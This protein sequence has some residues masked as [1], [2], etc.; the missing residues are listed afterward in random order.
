MRFS[1]Y[2]FTHMSDY[3]QGDED[4]SNAFHRGVDATTRDAENEQIQAAL[5][6]S[7][8]EETIRQSRLEEDARGGRQ[9]EKGDGP[10]PAEDDSDQGGDDYKPAAPSRRGGDKEALQPRTRYNR[11]CKSQSNSKHDGTVA[12]GDVDWEDAANKAEEEALA[13]ED[14]PMQVR[15]AHTDA[16]TKNTPMD[17]ARYEALPDTNK[18]GATVCPGQRCTANNAKGKQCG[19]RT[20]N[21]Q[22][23][24]THTQLIH[25]VRIKPSTIKNAGKGLFA[26]KDT[27]T[28]TNIAAY[29]GDLTTGSKDDYGGSKYV[30]ELSRGY[31]IDARRTNTAPGRMINDPRGTGQRPNCEFRADQRAKTITLWTTRPVAKGEE[32]T[33]SYGKEFWKRCTARKTGVKEHSGHGAQAQEPDWESDF[34]EEANLTDP[35]GAAAPADDG[36]PAEGGLETKIHPDTVRLGIPAT[37]KQARNRSDTPHWAAS[38]MKE[39]RSHLKKKTYSIVNRS[40]MPPG[41]IVLGT[42][43]VYAL[44][45]HSDGTPKMYK[46][47]FTIRGDEQR[48]GID[49]KDTRAGVLKLGSLRTLCALAAKHDLEFEASDVETAFLHGELSEPLYCAPM[50][51]MPGVGPGQVLKLHKTVYGLCQ[52]SHEWM[53]KLNATL[54]GAGY[55]QTGADECLWTKTS[56]TGR[57]MIIG[58]YVDDLPRVFH[59]VDRQEMQGDMRKLGEEYT[60][61]DLGEVDQIL[62]W[63]VTRDRKAGTMKI[64]QEGYITNLLEQYGMDE[65]GPIDSPGTPVEDLLGTEGEPEQ[66]PENGKSAREEMGKLT[67]ENFRRLIGALLYAACSTRPDIAYMISLLSS[68]V[69]DPQDR[70]LRALKKVLRYL[71]GT[72]AHGIEYHRGKDLEEGRLTLFVDS[73]HAGDKRD[74]RSITGFIA[75]F[76]GAPVTWAAKKQK[77]VANSS[78]EAEYLAMGEAARETVWLRT[79]L[80]DLGETQLG[81]TTVRAD[82]RSAIHITQGE[83]KE[84]R[85]KHIDVK[86]HYIKELVTQGVLRLEWIPTAENQAD[87]CT[88][89]LDRAKFMP[90]RDQ[91]MKG[92]RSKGGEAVA[93]SA[94]GLDDAQLTGMLCQRRPCAAQHG[95]TYGERCTHAAHSFANSIHEQCCKDCFTARAQMMDRMCNTFSGAG[96]GRLL[97]PDRHRA[98][99][100]DKGTP[101]QAD[102]LTT[103]TG[104]NSG[105]TMAQAYS[106]E[107]CAMAGLKKVIGAARGKTFDCSE[108]D[109]EP[110]E[111]GAAPAPRS[112]DHPLPRGKN[113]SFVPTKRTPPIMRY[114]MY[115]QCDPCEARPEDEHTCGAALCVERAYSYPNSPHGQC[116]ADCFRA[117]ASALQAALIAAGGIS[118]EAVR[119]AHDRGTTGD[120]NLFRRSYSDTD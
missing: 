85:R 35:M 102:T 37:A 36:E 25:S 111:S 10:E 82:N 67:K 108:S 60:L 94:Q 99:N 93:H 86:H 56:R 110:E 20:R 65:C 106:A 61:K 55:R 24:W 103:V 116:C 50:P 22:Y 54:K 13:A 38:E 53:K 58:T 69:A 33:V 26:A 80:A 89:G 23:C 49:Y 62:G 12:L 48:P 34:E 119:T 92:T 78:T 76:A 11:A 72:R 90:L 114:A 74:R 101:S 42:K 52:A 44:K 97:P 70:H 118:R 113:P 83:G 7:R 98:R 16:A 64:D 95:C 18:H 2:T 21:G 71:N 46:A 6:R 66:R 57:L 105:A 31:A 87:L 77:S 75:K 39:H 51:G 96:I 81:A 5:K 100:W 79:L 9:E 84:E 112:P 32:Y 29:T 3:A 63:R 8:E 1:E 117:R 68:F 17:E 41:S 4:D 19:A 104:G 45:L 88:K 109:G 40:E 91:L 115:C 15:Q 73:D 43:A 30:I 27:P 107:A 47:R 14:E 28:A 120:G 59:A